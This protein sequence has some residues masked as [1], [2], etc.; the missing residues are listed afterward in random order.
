MPLLSCL[1]TSGLVTVS[2]AKK[3]ASTM[4]RNAVAI[5]QEILNFCQ[6][7]VAEYEVDVIRM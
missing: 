4:K 5:K 2:L 1:A 3:A 6:Q 7:N